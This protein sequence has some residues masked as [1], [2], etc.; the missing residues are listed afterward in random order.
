MVTFFQEVV[1]GG[2]RDRRPS[3]V[4]RG[5]T[6]PF[7]YAMRTGISNDGTQDEQPPGRDEMRQVV[8]HA[9]NLF[10]RLLLESLHFDDLGD[11]HVIGLTDGLSGHVRRPREPIIRDRVQRPADDVAI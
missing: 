7:K 4:D 5:S 10:G 11:Q 9:L 3:L 6:G 8:L 1:A 2:W